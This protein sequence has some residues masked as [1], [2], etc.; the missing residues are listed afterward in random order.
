MKTIRVN[1][2]RLLRSPMDMGNTE[3]KEMVLCIRA[4]MVV[5]TRTWELEKSLLDG[6]TY[7]S[8]M[9]ARNGLARG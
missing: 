4:H 9:Y 8:G 1:R 7:R 6:S 3:R 5:T 2:S